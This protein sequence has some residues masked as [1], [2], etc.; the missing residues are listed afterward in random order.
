MFGIGTQEILLILLLVVVVFGYKKL[1]EIASGMGKAI[2]NFRR[3]ASEP[4]EIDITPGKEKKNDGND[5][6]A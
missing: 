1:P 6:R 3:A 2:H 5:P 4:D